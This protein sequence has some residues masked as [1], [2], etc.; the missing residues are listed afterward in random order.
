MGVRPSGGTDFDH[1]ADARVSFER[2]K[3]LRV[4]RW[5]ETRTGEEGQ[6]CQRNVRGDFERRVEVAST[7]FVGRRVGDRGG[8]P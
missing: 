8:S 4:A 7:R 2:R 6:I 5:A 3:K 1:A